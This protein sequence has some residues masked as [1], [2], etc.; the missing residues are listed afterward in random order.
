M[1]KHNPK[2]NAPR[3]DAEGYQID[4]HE[5]NGEALP[6]PGKTV[7][8]PLSHGGARP[9]AGRKKLGR[10]P[11]QLRLN[12]TTVARLRARAAAEHKT[13]SEVAEERLAAI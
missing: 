9:G 4:M 11:L 13:I 1:K 8:K 2:E 6:Q 5:I 10:Q 3:F 12:P 7:F